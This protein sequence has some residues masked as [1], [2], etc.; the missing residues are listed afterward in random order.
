MQTQT[1]KVLSACALGAFMGDIVAFQ[2]NHNF[3]WIGLLAGFSMGFLTYEFKTVVAAIPKAWRA[4]S[5]LRW[6]PNKAFWRSYPKALLTVALFA[7]TICLPLAGLVSVG[8]VRPYL[9]SFLWALATHLSF[10]IVMMPPLLI[11]GVKP[12]QTRKQLNRLLRLNLFYVYLW[13]VPKCLFNGILWLICRA[14][15]AVWAIGAFLSR[16]LKFTHS[17][18]RLLCGI[19]AAVGA[20]V[21]YYFGKAVWGIL[22]GVLWG[23]L[24]FEVISILWLKVVPQERSLFRR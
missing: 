19:D 3:W 9:T 13:V 11:K 23:V 20:A 14:P 4:A 10:M 6:H 5:T 17:E 24:N 21:G 8:S 1:L 12:E 15:R 18:I 16:L 22:A 2:I 7:P